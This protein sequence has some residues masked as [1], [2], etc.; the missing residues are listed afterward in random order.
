MLVPTLAPASRQILAAADSSAFPRRPNT[1]ASAQLPGGG[2]GRQG[3]GRTDNCVKR[4]EGEAKDGGGA[5]CGT[6]KSRTETPRWKGSTGTLLPTTGPLGN[7]AWPAQWGSTVVWW[8]QQH[9]CAL[10]QWLLVATQTVAFRSDGPPHQALQ[11]SDLL[12]HS[13]T[14]GPRNPSAS[15]PP[16]LHPLQQHENQLCSCVTVRAKS[17]LPR[18]G[19]CSGS[20]EGYLPSL[21]RMLRLWSR[22]HCATPN[23]HVRKGG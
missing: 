20:S 15:T 19:A 4:G 7:A 1:P 21:T 9:E 13:P 22:R 3:D 17:G 8:S 11:V 5:K 10:R 14:T 12:S 16:V 18:L 2:Q 6:G 23:L